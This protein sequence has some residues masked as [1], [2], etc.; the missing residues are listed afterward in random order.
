M[1]PSF[2]PWRRRA[3]TPNLGV[4]VITTNTSQNPVCIHGPTITFERF[5]VGKKSRKFFAC[6]ACRDRKEC[7]F[8]MW[9]DQTQSKAYRNLWLQKIKE[10]KPKRSHLE[11][12]RRLSAIASVSPDERGYCTVCNVLCQLP[13]DPDHPPTPLC[14]AATV[15]TPV[16]DHLLTHPSRLV[17]LKENSKC[18]AQYLF[19]ERSLSAVVGMVA[20]TGATKLLCVGV[21]SLHEAVAN[22]ETDLAATSMLL[23]I[24]TRYRNFFPLTSFVRFN[25]FNQHFFDGPK[26]RQRVL[27]FLSGAK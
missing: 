1:A 14:S 7:P 25:M 26:A 22:K 15:I 17:P 10:N 4:E 18:E 23:D 9:A 19:S 11:E 5:F 12:Y 6:S 21:P 24:D 13:T 27:R 16:S 8:F 2:P 20:A 3:P